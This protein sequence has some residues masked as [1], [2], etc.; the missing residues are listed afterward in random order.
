M[1]KA[2]I[3]WHKRK[4]LI[5]KIVEKVKIS[6]NLVIYILKKY[7]YKIIKLI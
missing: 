4:K 1:I 7:R 2:I 6:Q 5:V 3:N